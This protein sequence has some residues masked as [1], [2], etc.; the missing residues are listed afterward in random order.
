MQARPDA[1]TDWITLPEAARYLGLST[2]TVRRRIK[3]GEYE[4]RLERRR[5]GPT[6]MLRAD[7]LPVPAPAVLAAMVE[8]LQRQVT[9]LAD[10]LELLAARIETLE[11]RAG[12]RQPLASSSA[13]VLLARRSPLHHTRLGSAFQP[14]QGV[15]RAALQG[16][17]QEAF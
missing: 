16:P 12:C 15:L 7:R 13:V 6:W 14:G 2:Y 11:R 9:A 3:R 8:G 17:A 10:E 5:H 4:A 1:P